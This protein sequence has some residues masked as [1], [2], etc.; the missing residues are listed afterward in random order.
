MSVLTLQH[1]LVLN[2]KIQLGKFGDLIGFKQLDCT[3]SHLAGRAILQEVAQMDAFYRKREV[4]GE[5]LVKENK[6]VGF[7]GL[8][9]EQ[10]S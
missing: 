2:N 1:D 4:A 3:A 8:F 9:L 5:L 10:T 6:W 7:N